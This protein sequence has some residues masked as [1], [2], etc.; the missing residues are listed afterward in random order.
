MKYE[1]V[2]KNGKFDKIE[3]ESP[4]VLTE[5]AVRIRP[6][7]VGICGSDLYS[8]EI[9]PGTESLRPGHE[10]IGVVE[11]SNS[12]SY[13]K[14]DIVTS[15]VSFGC[16]KCRSCYDGKPNN[17]L[18]NQSLGGKE[19]GAL[20][21]EII[22]QDQYLINLSHLNQEGL[23]LIEV[24]AVAEQAFLHMADLGLRA[25]KK[26]RVMIFGAG[27]V[28]LFCALKAKKEGLNYILV[29][30]D[31]KR[32][33]IAKELGLNI[34]ATGAALLKD[35]YHMSFDYIIDCSGDGNKK[36]GFWKY[37]L[38]FASVSSKLLVVGKYIN[39]QKINSVLFTN[40]DVT[41]K[42]MRGL[43]KS[44]IEKAVVNWKEDLPDIGKSMITHEFSSVD[45]DKAFDI[46]L[47]RENTG[48]VVVKI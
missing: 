24:A 45:V 36:S 47:R 23:V 6:T 33:E 28:G 37:F 19:I 40:R 43:P 12:S 32:I 4:D 42:W 10:W 25:G 35:D 2:Y 48:K 26:D 30:L 31:K 44:V 41:I 13:Q 1:L 8:I 7:E 11:E 14:G 20:R 27:P 39:E 16:Q 46:A 21:N 22:L 38:H 9:L 5:G 17:C 15:P 3:I 18:N 29:E 34:I